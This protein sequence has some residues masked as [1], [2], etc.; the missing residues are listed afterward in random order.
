MPEVRSAQARLNP[1]KSKR[2]MD[3]A[4]GRKRKL[5]HREPNGRPKRASK[6]DAEAGIMSVVLE[7]RAKVVGL[8][9][10]LR[11]HKIECPLGLLRYF[12]QIDDRQYDAGVE[13]RKVVGIM[14]RARAIP[15]PHARSVDLGA[16]AG[17]SGE[18]RRDLEPE[19]YGRVLRRYQDAFRALSDAGRDAVLAVNELVVHERGIPAHQ[20]AALEMG[21]NLLAR[22]FGLDKREK[23]A[24]AG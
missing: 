18:D 4:R 16:V 19:E 20:M 13:Y 6:G 11:D 9:G 23:S 2:R 15:S 14:R 7:Q 8:K 22:H 17:G 5:A 12:N 10:H 1:L 3:M 21:L 24:R